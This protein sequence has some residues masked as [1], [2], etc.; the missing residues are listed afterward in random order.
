M[1]FTATFLALSLFVVAT[2]ASPPPRPP[3]KQPPP[4]PPPK[5]EQ[6]QVE[7]EVEQEIEP[8]PPDQEGPGSGGIVGAED[9]KIV[10]GTKAGEGAYPHQVSLRTNGRHFCGGSV[11]SA[12]WVLTAAHCTVGQSPSRIS[13]VVGTN[14]LNAG[15]QTYRVQ[16]IINHPS[17]NRNNN[18]NDISLLQIAGSGI[19]LSGRVRTI[20]LASSPA[21]G[22]ASATLSGWGLT[23]YPGMSLPNDLQQITLNVL[24]YSQCRANL[25]GYPVFQS[26]VCTLKGVGQGACQGDSG[27]PLISGGQQIGVVSWGIP[28]ARGRPD[29]FTSVASF[30]S[31]IKQNTGV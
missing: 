27:G 7:Q 29:V 24:S 21:A 17:Y 19:A 9:E 5:D 14:R 11:I 18:Q 1:K 3:S 4:P 15:G 20:A 8:P 25:A 2:L 10:G 31:W 30:R 22:G 16:R 26:H 12:G 6:Q 23:S 28:C 13:V